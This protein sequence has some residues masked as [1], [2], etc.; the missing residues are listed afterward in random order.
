[1]SLIVAF[2]AGAGFLSSVLLQAA[3]MQR[4]WLRYALCIAIAYAVF[5]LLIGLWRRWREWDLS[6]DLTG[7][8][9]GQGGSAQNWGGQG[10]SSGGGGASASFDG[11][12]SSSPMESAGPPDLPDLPDVDIGEGIWLLP[13][14]LIAGGM[15]I[16][17]AWLIWV[18][19]V[20]LAEVAVDAALSAGLY[21]RLRHS[22]TEDWFFATLRH[23][24]KPFFLA[25]TCAVIIGAVLGHLAPGA[26]TLGDAMSHLAR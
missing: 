19:P 16:S 22:D 11:A 20:L 9:P 7:S 23:T 18:A 13:L 2:T 3:G 21:R 25:G 4:M 10:G 14:L 8:G 17:V 26:T 1:M 12:S 15:L 6:F 5:I 24:W